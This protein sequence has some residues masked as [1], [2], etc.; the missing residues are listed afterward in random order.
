[1]FLENHNSPGTDRILLVVV[2]EREKIGM[3]EAND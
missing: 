2:T 1:M 3:V